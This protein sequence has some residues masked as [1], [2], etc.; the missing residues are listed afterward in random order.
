[1]MVL[2]PV[3]IAPPFTVK[4]AVAVAPA[5]AAL[6]VDDPSDAVPSENVTAP[7][8]GLFP[9]NAFT[10]AVNWV[11]ALAEILDGL[12]VNEVVVPTAGGRLAQWVTRL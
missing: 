4:V 3:G 12:A 5:V 6:S 7:V 10:V 2:V 11:V 8:G 1:V 9:L